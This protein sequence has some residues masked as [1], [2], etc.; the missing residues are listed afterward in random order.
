MSDDPPTRGES[1]VRAAVRLV[2]VIGE[3]LGI[4]IDDAIARRRRWGH[5]AAEA[6]AVEVGNDQLLIDRLQDDRLALLLLEAVEAAARSALEEK[7]RLLG[8]VVGRAVL[9][10][11]QVDEAQLVVA[12][13]RGL[14]APH[15]RAL[16]R[17]ARAARHSSGWDDLAQQEAV[18]K[19]SD[20]E[21]E[22]V[23]A[24]LLAH[25]AVYGA[26]GYGGSWLGVVR[27]TDFGMRLLKDLHRA[28]D[29]A[30]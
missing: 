3:S 17:L 5:E 19:A 8:R 26:T 16:E 6:M 20:A 28:A 13:L 15:I 18:S 23:R 21:P 9:D 10:D 24:A 2:P 25:G 7:R 30:P 1:L 29:K 22:P 4:C 27:V 12:A 14:D 11:A